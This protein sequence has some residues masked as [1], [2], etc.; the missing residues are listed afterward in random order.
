MNLDDMALPKSNET[1]QKSIFFQRALKTAILNT[2]TKME[3]ENDYHF[4]P[5]EIDDVLL[6]I[7]KQH[8]NSYLIGKFGLPTTT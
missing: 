2:I 4:Q 7:L 1:R 3:T 5:Y 8:H 6:D